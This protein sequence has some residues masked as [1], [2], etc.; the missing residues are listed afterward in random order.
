[1]DMRP[2]NAVNGTRPEVQF[3]TNPVTERSLV[4]YGQVAGHIPKNQNKG[5][6][7]KEE[8]AKRDNVHQIFHQQI[9]TS[10][11]DEVP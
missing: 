11:H 4:V 7:A 8:K 5:S 9:V 1:M 6:D 10:G 2:P 3:P